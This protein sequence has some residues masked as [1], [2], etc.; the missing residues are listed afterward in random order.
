M[1]LESLQRLR[2]IVAN[3]RGAGQVLAVVN[4]GDSVLVQQ[5]LEQLRGEIFRADRSTRIFVHEERTRRGQLLGL[6]DAVKHRREVHG[7]L[8]QEEVALGIMMPGK[9]TRLSPITQRLYGIKSFFPMPMRSR[10]NGP[11][12]SAASA[13]LYSWT[14]VTYHL[15]RLGFRGIA[16]KWGDEPQF[17][18]CALEALETDLSEVDAVRFGCQSVITEDLARN[19]EWLQR[20]P[21]T[22]HLVKQVRRRSRKELLRCFS[23]EDSP[24]CAA[25]VHIGSPAVSHVFIQAMEEVFGELSGWIDIDGYLFEALTH[26]K[27]EWHMEVSRDS[28]LQQLL[29]QVPDYYERVQQVKH[30]IEAR[31]KHPMVVHVIDFGPGLYWGDIG[32]LDKARKVFTLLM[33]PGQNGEFARALAQIDRIA[34]D[35]NGNRVVGHCEIS[36]RADVRNSVLVDSVI[37]GSAMIRS[38]VVMECE[39]GNATMCPDSL[40]IRCTVGNFEAGKRAFGFHS[41]ASELS[42][43]D[44]FVHTSIAQDPLA[45]TGAV[46]DW[47]ARNSDNPGSGDNYS[48]VQYGNPAA[49]ESKFLQMR[50]RDVG[51]L[52]QE[53]NIY[54]KARAQV[55]C[56]ATKFRNS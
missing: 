40:A 9:G 7:P 24:S 41:I 44:D 14:A 37:H 4:E 53:Q 33:D 26:T 28:V 56:L 48:V 46:Q 39:F 31:R 6:L 34:P 25:H 45:S 49:Y 21:D 20:D 51:P 54:E 5:Q 36:P 22:G 1:K 30:K 2:D 38:A 13:S 11:W 15:Q 35:T 23:M 17:P 55:R 29:Q 18:A 32:Q 19:K 27:E 43:K 42:I 8:S 47:W 3:S 16:W 52:Q 12:L 50:Q 10:Y